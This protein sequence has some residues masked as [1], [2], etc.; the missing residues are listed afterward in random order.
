[1]APLPVA[2]RDADALRKFL[3]ETHRIE[4]PVTAHAGHHFVRVSVAGYTTEADLQALETALR[5]A[6]R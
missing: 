6:P 4:V 3:F 1:M 2:T 5:D